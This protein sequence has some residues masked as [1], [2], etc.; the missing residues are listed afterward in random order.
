[1]VFKM[2]FS[3]SLIRSRL[4]KSSSSLVLVIVLENQRVANSNRIMI[5]DDGRVRGRGRIKNLAP[6]NPH[7]A[8]RY[9]FLRNFRTSPTRRVTFLASKN[10][11]SGMT[12]LRETP[13]ISLNWGVVISPLSS[14]NS[15]SFFFKPPSYSQKHPSR[16]DVMVAN[17]LKEA[18]VDKFRE[19]E[20]IVFTEKQG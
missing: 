19:G 20:R 12:N 13:V 9:Y 14:R 6:R 7:R 2:C 10:S 3:G 1:M 18:K 17:I 15:T 11:A 4:F 5:E 16:L 8:T